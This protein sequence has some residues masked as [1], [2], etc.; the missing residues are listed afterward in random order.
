MAAKLTFEAK[1]Q[2]MEQVLDLLKKAEE[3]M[4]DFGR[5]GTYAIG[6][7]D[8]RM[9]EFTQSLEYINKAQT[10][11][12]GLFKSF[13]ELNKQSNQFLGKAYKGVIDSMKSEVKEFSAET[14]KV[15]QKI[16]D[17]ERE[18]ESF[19]TKRGMMSEQEFQ[20]GVRQRQ[21]ELSMNQAEGSAKRAQQFEMERQLRFASPINEG[22]YDFAQRFGMGK[23]ATVG[24]VLNMIP[25]ILGAPATIGQVM[26]GAGQYGMQMNF[27]RDADAFLANARLSRSAASQAM[28][29]DPT[30]LLLQSIGGGIEKPGMESM[31]S[32]LSTRGRWIMDNSWVR[33]IA[34]GAAGFWAG[35]LP[36]L[37]IGAIPGAAIGFGAGFASAGNRTISQIEAEQRGDLRQRDLEMYGVLGKGSAGQFMRE[38][39]EL[40]RVQRMYGIAGTHDLTMNLAAQGLN[41]NRANPILNAMLA[42]GMAPTDDMGNIAGTSHVFERY[43]LNQ[44]ARAAVMR[45]TALNGGPMD[46]NAL[47]AVSLF[48]GAGL[49]GIRD[50]AAQGNLSDYATGLLNTRGAGFDIASAGQGVAANVAMNA[51]TFNKVEGV[52][53]GIMNFESQNRLMGGGSTAVDTIMIAALRGLGVT[54]PIHIDMLIKMGGKLGINDSKVVNTIINLTGKSE[55]E[56][57]SALRGIATTHKRMSETVIGKENI[58][59]FNKAS[60]GDALTLLNAGERAFDNTTRGGATFS[61]GFENRMGGGG[62]G[63]ASTVA[64]GEETFEDK[65]AGAE[66]EKEFQLDA[67]MRRVLE[68]TGKKVTEEITGAILKGFTNT[69]EEV[70]KAA[71]NLIRSQ[72]REGASAPNG[73]TNAPFKGTKT[74]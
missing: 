27:T 1:M 39:T 12:G 58:D 43:Q 63:A 53:Q 52:Q 64:K 69:A 42:N 51:P 13:D 45:A 7:V 25:G 10:G 67:D 29:G 35:G 66:A 26:Q 24:G 22:V 54:N 62:A 61:E 9:K 38:G 59:A 5:V 2:G 40:T 41:Y 56:V 21:T 28:S 19:K 55:A 6:G 72:Q 57:R 15:L 47:R 49:T 23:H 18:L 68:G 74:K 50:V 16:R 31:S 17:S 60:G 71:D 48:G 65:L 3:R 36:T 14:D 34:G 44:N 20:S 46:A 73:S 11:M 30:T 8:T 4:S 70:R 37:G 32:W 33:G